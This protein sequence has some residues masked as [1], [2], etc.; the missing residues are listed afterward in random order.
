MTSK[1]IKGLQNAS[2]DLRRLEIEIHDAGTEA[3]AD[4]DYD[5]ASK[6]QDACAAL[7]KAMS[8]LNAV[9]SASGQRPNHKAAGRSRD[10]YPRFHKEHD[11]LVRIG[12]SKSHNR[13]YV[14]RGAR[15]VVDSIVRALSL[16]ANNGT[17]VTTDKVVEA[18]AADQI[19]NYQIYLCLGWLEKEG[20][21]AKRGRA[22]WLVQEPA[23]LLREVD[24]RWKTLRS[25]QTR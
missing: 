17:P 1:R 4:R 3:F 21:V 18:T 16:V 14:Q 7:A 11:E 20:L 25:S 9:V 24:R 8:A 5:A 22:G 12:W 15:Q 6:C 13:E 2:K 10:G 19:P 23:Q